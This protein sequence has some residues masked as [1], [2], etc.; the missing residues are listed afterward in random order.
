MKKMVLYFGLI[1][2]VSFLLVG[3]AE[4]IDRVTFTLIEYDYEEQDYFVSDDFV[5]IPRRLLAN[6]IIEKRYW[7]GDYYYDLQTVR[8][9]WLVWENPL[10]EMK[11]GGN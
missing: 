5:I 8:G 11:K 9:G 1:L 2:V 4:K 7:H 10:E 6:A 3:C